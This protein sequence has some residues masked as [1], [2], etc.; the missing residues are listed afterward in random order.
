[1]FVLKGVY[2]GEFKRIIPF[3]QTSD[4]IA[5]EYTN[6]ADKEVIAIE[7]GS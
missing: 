4:T 7:L 1:M 5:Q 6:V 2:K 3:N